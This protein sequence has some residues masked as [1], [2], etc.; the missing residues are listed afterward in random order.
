MGARVYRIPEIEQ[1]LARENPRWRYENGAIV[2]TFRTQSWKA[3]LLAAG[4]VAHLAEAAWHHP[5]MILN[6][7]SLEVRL[8]THD[9]GGV[10]DKDFELAAQ[11]EKVVG[12]RPQGGALEGTPQDA[13]SAYI[14]YDA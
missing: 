3:T 12:W 4:A 6:Y 2:R 11:I 7:P 9:A 14:K 5:E 10:T 1:R 8:N 13:A